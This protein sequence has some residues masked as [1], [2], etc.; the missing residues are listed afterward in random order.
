MKNCLKKWMQRWLPGL[1]CLFLAWPALAQLATYDTATQVLSVPMLKKD[2]VMYTNATFALPANAAWAQSG[3]GTV[4]TTLSSK[5]PAVYDTTK[6]TLTLPYVKIDTSYFFDVQL[7]LPVGQVWTVLSYGNFNQ[8]E[9]ITSNLS[10]PIR[11]TVSNLYGSD[12]AGYQVYELDNGQTWRIVDDDPCFPRLTVNEASEFKGSSNVAIYPDPKGADYLWIASYGGS[13]ESCTVAPVTLP[14]IMVSAQGGTLSSSVPSIT[15]VPSK[16]YDLYIT[17]GTQPYFLVVNDPTVASV[18]MI[19]QIPD[20]A[21]QTARVT[22]NRPGTANL[23]IFDFNRNKIDVP[24]TGQSD[25]LVTPSEI[26]VAAGGSPIV[27]GIFGGVPPYQVFNPSDQR[28][29]GN[30]ALT[31]VGE[32]FYT[33]QLTFLAATG[34]KLP[35]Y[36]LDSTG[37]MVA[38]SVTVTGDSGSTGTGTGTG[39]SGSTG[40]GTGTSTGTSGTTKPP[41]K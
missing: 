16:G 29:V 28:W 4:S 20:R 27:V 35:I 10:F 32:N 33:M 30:S 24:L 40:T 7:S 13:A 5:V 12:T 22:F 41:L 39:G 15:G 38:V 37:A 18:Q 17:G 25:L 19:S 11:T 23:S 14:G 6:A 36:I 8:F 2:G 3:A 1:I 31:K 26:S 9:T 34:S 21:G